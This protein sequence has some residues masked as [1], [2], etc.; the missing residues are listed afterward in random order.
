MTVQPHLTELADITDFI[1]SHATT[2]VLQRAA[3]VCSD[4]RCRERICEA[5]LLLMLL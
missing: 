4:G 1:L 3:Y 5:H 2:L